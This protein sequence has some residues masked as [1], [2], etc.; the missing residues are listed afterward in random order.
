V[1]ISEL[2]NNRVNNVTDILQEGEEVLV[3]CIDV[4]KSGK[5]RLSRRAALGE[6]LGGETA[7]A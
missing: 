1:H 6:A 5:I 7:Q 2:A 4:D 3:K